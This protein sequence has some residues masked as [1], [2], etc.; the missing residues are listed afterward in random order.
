MN[1]LSHRNISVPDNLHESRIRFHSMVLPVTWDCQGV[2]RVTKSLACAPS[3]PISATPLAGHSCSSRDRSSSQEK[4]RGVCQ[5]A[6]VVRTGGL[7]GEQSAECG[8]VQDKTDGTC[9][10][11]PSAEVGLSD[12]Y[13]FQAV[14]I[15][16]DQ[17]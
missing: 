7:F 17:D 1:I 3:R 13:R 12:C 8:R 14:S 11:G 4:P 10:L 5:S 2:S 15:L 9:K 16:P 6:W